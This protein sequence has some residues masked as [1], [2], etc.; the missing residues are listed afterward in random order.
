MKTLYGSAIASPSDE[1]EMISVPQVGED[2][3]G[4]ANHVPK[5]LLVGIIAPRARR[6]ASSWCAT[7]SRPRASTRSS[8][9][10]SC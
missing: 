4:N 7:A 8:A 2:D 3:D 1:R 6:D 5:S 9:A 10:A